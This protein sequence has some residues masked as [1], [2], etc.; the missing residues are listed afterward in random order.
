MG[1]TASF[2]E[3]SQRWQAVG[4]TLFGLTGPR[5]EPQTSS[6]REERVTARPSGRFLLQNILANHIISIVFIA[7]WRERATKVTL[8]LL[9]HTTIV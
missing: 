1:N 6:F 9:Y 8:T 4:N 2:E 5:F 7:S 3:M